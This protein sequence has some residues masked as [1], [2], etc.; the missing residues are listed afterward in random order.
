MKGSLKGF[1]LGFGGNYYGKDNIINTKSAG[2]FATDAYTL[3]NA[4]VSYSQKAYTL[5]LS[6]DN[7]FDTNI[8]MVVVDLLRLAICVR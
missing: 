3:F 2:T 6:G 5:S 1:S 4:V 8:T 7:I